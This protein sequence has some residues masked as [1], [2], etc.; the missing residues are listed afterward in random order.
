V[1]T[2]VA[3]VVLGSALAASGAGAQVKKKEKKPDPPPG[4]VVKPFS[5]ENPAA[6]FK[7][8]L[9]GYVQADF[10]S[11]QDWTAENA[12]GDSSLPPDFD[13][14]R[15]RIGVEGDWRRLSWDAN[16]DPAFDKGNELKDAW[17]GLRLSKAFQLRGGNMKVPTS[18][19]FLASPAK[20][21]FVERAAFVDS[22]GPNR[23]WGGLVH[24]EISRVV[25]Y[26]AG[27]FVGDN[28]TSDNSAGTTGAGR[29]VL[30]PTRW[31]GLGGSFAEGDVQADPA[32]PG[33]DPGPKGLP[34]QSVTGYRFFPSV[35]VNGRRLRW[36]GDVRLESGPFSLWGEFLETREER[37]GQ[38][39]TLLDLPEVRGDGWSATVT[40]LVTGEKKRRT[41]QPRR[42]LFHGPGAI[43][44]AARYESLRFDDVENQGFESAGS[45]AAN[46]RPAGYQALTSGLS[47]WPSP[48][49]RLVGDVVVERYDDELRAPEPGKKGDYVTLLGRVQVHLP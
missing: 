30:R 15:A 17:I 6:G 16:V 36:G 27:V 29:L 44:I 34:G 48:F 31:L 43:E 26:Q 5:L 23:D 33:L 19:E 7:I 13:W 49:L 40:W 3:V 35:Y 14:R 2:V 9:K 11:Y 24:G 20:T 41:I 42:S 1:R 22:I 46:I 47:W 12:A 32:G 10:R 25:E 28:R 39:P 18:P 4:W 8:A 45:R 21:D 37:K 38:G